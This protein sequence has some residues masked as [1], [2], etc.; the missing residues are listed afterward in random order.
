VKI[1]FSPR[2]GVEIGEHVF[3]TQKFEGVYKKG[4]E[5]QFFRPEDVIEPTLPPSADFQGFFSEEYLKD[6]LK[7]RHTS[8]TFLSEL[9]VKQDIIESQFIAA[10]GTYLTAW[11]ALREGIGFHIGGGFHHAYADHAEGFCYVNDLAYALWRLKKEGSL[12]RSAVIDC[13]LHQ[14][15]GTASY[16][17]N[18][19]S[20]FTFSIHQEW[21]YPMPKERSDLD[22]G[23]LNG[24]SD[25]EYLTRLQDALHTIFQSIT[26]ELIL[27]QAGV[28][29]YEEDQLGGLRLT[30]QGLRKR[31]ELVIG[32]CVRRKIPLAITL[33][34]GYPPSLSTLVELHLQTLEVAIKKEKEFLPR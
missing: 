12:Q 22:V 3:A 33:G 26:P 31:D 25:G 28:D 15:N 19:P 34:G 10:H 30:K 4:L 29:P 20:V 27:Y 32:E 8:R 2:Y 18:D 6:L 11:W 9:P 14:G 23:L 17:Q 16:F 24:V 21:N 13:D 7:A 5:K 1:I